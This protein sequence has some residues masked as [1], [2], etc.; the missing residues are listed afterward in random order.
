M[1]NF[2]YLQEQK[3]LAHRTKLSKGEKG[4][5]LYFWVILIA[6]GILGLTLD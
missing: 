1:M 5:L 2:Y 4:F 6:V 3:D